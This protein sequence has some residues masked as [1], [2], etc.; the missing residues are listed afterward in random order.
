MEKRLKFKSFLE[1]LC[2]SFDLLCKVNWFKWKSTEK[3]S[4][5]QTLSSFFLPLICCISVIFLLN[6]IFSRGS[7]RIYPLHW[8]SC[9]LI[10]SD[11]KSTS[12]SHCLYNPFKSV[13]QCQL[14]WSWFRKLETGTL[15]YV[16]CI[17]FLTYTMGLPQGRK[18]RSLPWRTWEG[19]LVGWV[20]FAHGQRL[21]MNCGLCLLKNKSSESAFLFMLI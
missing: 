2:S 3:F 4:L 6:L 21:L 15:I 14:H 5:G 7:D 9:G 18:N 10:L 8:S 11:P 12:L 13:F 20:R 19:K 17:S 16:G 1:R